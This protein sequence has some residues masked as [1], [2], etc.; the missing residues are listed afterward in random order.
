MTAVRPPLGD[1]LIAA[2][3]SIDSE[4]IERLTDQALDATILLGVEMG[5]DP[6]AFSED[7]RS[8]ALAVAAQVVPILVDYLLT[9]AGV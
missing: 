8:V 2:I 7:E 5:V 3:E 6:G 1:R 9:E 4:V